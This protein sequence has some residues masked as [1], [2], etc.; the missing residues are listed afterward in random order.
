MKTMSALSR[1][2]RLALLTMASVFAFGV[3][4]A[5]AQE[6]AAAAA[7]IQKWNYDELTNAPEKARAKQNPFEGDPDAVRAGGKLFERHCAEC[8]G[9]KA[10]GGKRAPSLLRAEVQ[11]APPGAIFWVLTNGVVWHGMPVWSKLPEPQRWQIVSFLKSFTGQS[12]PGP[13]PTTFPK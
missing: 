1:V 13:Q 2:T 7:N 4:K 3:S 9:M 8:H 11:Q 5:A 12:S 6:N 10:E